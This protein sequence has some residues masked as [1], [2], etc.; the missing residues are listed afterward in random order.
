MKY[1]IY[2]KSYILK[3]LQDIVMLTLRSKKEE[4]LKNISCIRNISMM[5]ET[6]LKRENGCILKTIL[7]F[8]C[9]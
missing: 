2:E 5:K 8:T 4:K 6:E 7:T 9:S 3:A 1:P